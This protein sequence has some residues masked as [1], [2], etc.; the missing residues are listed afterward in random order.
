MALNDNFLLANQRAKELHS[1]IPKAVLARYDRKSGRIVVDLSSRLSVSF[2]PRDA[3]GLGGARSRLNWIK[4]KLVPQD[5]DFTFRNWML[6][7]TCRDCWRD[8]LGRR[9]GW[10][11]D[12]V[13]LEGNP[14]AGRNARLLD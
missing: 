14:E 6:T 1:T 3:Q 13:R 12:W 5:L 8:F 9:N 2:S 7:S 10:L 11:R 4:L